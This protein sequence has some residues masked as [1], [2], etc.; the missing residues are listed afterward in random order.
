MANGG[1]AAGRGAGTANETA[2]R[3]RRA[4]HHL[5]TR[6]RREVPGRLGGP[7]RRSPLAA[8]P[9]LQSN[10]GPVRGP[11]VPSLPD[12]ELLD[13]KEPSMTSSS[14][15]ETEPLD[16][17]GEAKAAAPRPRHRDDGSANLR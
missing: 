13:G 10:V 2:G 15:Q 7:A 5:F 16:R 3:D 6:R 17:D 12:L 9:H 1:P 8:R 4:S 14:H 11:L